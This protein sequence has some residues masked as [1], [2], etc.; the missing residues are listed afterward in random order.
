MKKLLWA[1][2]G[3]CLS[4][5][6][7]ADYVSAQDKDAAKMLTLNTQ[8]NSGRPDRNLKTEFA[9]AKKTGPVS[10]R[11]IRDFKKS[12]PDVK[13]VSWVE[14]E[15]GYIAHF[16]IDGEKT[17]VAYDTRG[18]WQYLLRERHESTMPKD[19][20]AQVRSCYYDYSIS[21]VEELELFDKTIYL[22]L[23]EDN[24]SWKRLRISDGE[25][26]LIGDYKKNR[27]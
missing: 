24:K 27:F 9:G 23:L 13:H 10:I 17:K 7:M 8:A 19:V 25:M 3:G 20:R 14:V 18:S 6:A 26:E 5:F 16:D 1:V 2:A 15:D 4:V 22:V 12:Y 11:A 21:Q